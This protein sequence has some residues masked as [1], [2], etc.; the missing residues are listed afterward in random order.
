MRRTVERH[1][2]RAATVCLSFGIL[3]SAMTALCQ[4]AAENTPPAPGSFAGYEVLNYAKRMEAAPAQRGAAKGAR[5]RAADANSVETW[6]VRSAAAPDSTYAVRQ[7]TNLRGGVELCAY[8]PNRVLAKLLPGKDYAAFAAA[9]A[10]EGFGIVRE[11]MRDKDG[12]PVYIVESQDPETDVFETM[13]MSIQATEMCDDVF[14]D[15]I[16][17]LD[18]VPNDALYHEQWALAKIGAPLAWETRTDASS[19]LVGV[20]DS[21]VNNEHVDLLRNLWLNEGEI[22]G[23]GIDNDGNGVVDDVFG[24]ASAGGKLSG[25]TMDE[26]GHGSHCAGII[27]AEGNNSKFVSGVAW[28]A[29]IMPLK[30]V[31]ANGKGSTSDS[32][33]CLEYADRMGVKIVNCSFKLTGAFWDELLFE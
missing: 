18:A 20:L 9:M 23:D 19:V 1:H 4:D 14:P 17:D 22:P 12:N 15:Y 24:V 7:T 29:R 8:T 3:L 13:S 28:T 31:R 16:Y 25:Y 26:V 11:L 30:F 2:A 6:V 5:L 33:S 21:G 27:G 10:A 32:I